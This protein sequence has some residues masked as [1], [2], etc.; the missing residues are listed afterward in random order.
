MPTDTKDLI[1]WF[2]TRI[3]RRFPPK[4]KS[5]LEHLL[6]TGKKVEFEALNYGPFEI[7][8][9]ASLEKIIDSQKRPDSIDEEFESPYFSIEYLQEHIER[10][11]AKGANPDVIPFA[12][13]T[14]GDKSRYIYFLPNSEAP[15][16]LDINRG[17]APEILDSSIDS[18]I[19][20]EKIYNSQETTIN[21]DN[22]I[23]PE[24][25]VSPDKIL[26][27]DGEAA[28]DVQDYK[29]VIES[30]FNLSNGA[31][32]LTSFSGTEEN[33]TRILKIGINNKEAVLKVDG[34][35]GWVDQPK[36]IKQLNE[37]IKPYSNGNKFFEFRGFHWGQEFGVVYGDETLKNEFRRAGYLNYII[38]E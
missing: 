37:A 31:L 14:F 32:Q 24:Q 16:T 27:M 19:D 5:L 12:I 22:T 38:E 6:S 18:F 28:D 11:E 3:N 7:M 8:N 4:I 29:G 13:S 17:A 36:L 21:F 34:N 33:G 26:V 2:E 1:T 35:T 30:F 23:A 20:I 15:V 9:F 10:M 25:L